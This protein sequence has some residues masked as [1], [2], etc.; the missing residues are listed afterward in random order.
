[1]ENA[2]GA[3]KMTLWIAVTTVCV[4]GAMAQ[5]QQSREVW[6]LAITPQSIADG[7]LRASSS[8]NST[9]GRIVADPLFTR[10]FHCGI[11]GR[12]RLDAK[13]K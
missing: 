3:T 2:P 13:R 1:M 9:L 4:W 11:S 8:S 6:A 5:A 7:H 12:V 10:P